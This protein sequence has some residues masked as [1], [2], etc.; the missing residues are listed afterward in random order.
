[1]PI[2]TLIKNIQCQLAYVV[3]SPP[4]AGPTT[5][6]MSAGQV[7]NPIA[8]MIPSL[9]VFFKT[10]IRP[11]GTIKAP[12]I[13]CNTLAKIKKFKLS[14]MPHKIDAAV[15]I[16][17]ANV[18]T[19]RAPKR[20]AN[21]PLIGIMTANVSKYAVMPIPTSTAYVLKSIAIMG[22]A[23]AMTVLSKVSIKKVVATR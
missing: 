4:I 16:N 1:M 18:K 22:N 7:I 23:V 17:I 3:N 14:L 6:P 8:A 20:S 13:P 21:H 11:T 5:G 10:M 9:G 15:N 2:G 19:L 12:P